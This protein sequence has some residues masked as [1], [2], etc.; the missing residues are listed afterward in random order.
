MCRKKKVT[1]NSNH[2]KS[3]VRL[4]G[5]RVQEPAGVE[6]T[7]RLHRAAVGARQEASASGVSGL[8]V[9][10]PKMEPGLGTRP[11][12]QPNWVRRGKVSKSL[13]PLE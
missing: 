13:H 6:D 7:P 2:A 4:D 8:R 11:E 10:G 5:N 12:G 3:H 1:Y 9:S